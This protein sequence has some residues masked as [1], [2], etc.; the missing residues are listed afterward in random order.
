MDTGDKI[1][2][3]KVIA[4]VSSLLDSGARLVR[5]VKVYRDRVLNT[6][7][8]LTPQDHKDG[9]FLNLGHEFFYAGVSERI[10]TERVCRHLLERTGLVEKKFSLSGEGQFY[11]AVTGDS[12]TEVRERII[13]YDSEGRTK[14][15]LPRGDVEVDR[16]AKRVCR[17]LFRFEAEPENPVRMA[18]LSREKAE[19]FVAETSLKVGGDGGRAVELARPGVANQFQMEENGRGGEYV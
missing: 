11:K 2:R 16:F 14:L 1:A 9:G 17:V 6:L 5:E 18:I 7:K 12:R 19:R 3:E 13:S 10:I 4:G 8:Y 15:T